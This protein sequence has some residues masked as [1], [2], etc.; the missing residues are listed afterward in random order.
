MGYKGLFINYVRQKGEGGAFRNPENCLTLPSKL[1]Y[2]GE[3]GGSKNP[4]HS[5]VIDDCP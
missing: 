4:E 5:Y 2:E 1:P 3:G